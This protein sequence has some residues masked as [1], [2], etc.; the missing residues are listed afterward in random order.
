[1]AGHSKYDNGELP[2]GERREPYLRLAL[3]SLAGP[4]CWILHFA[5]VYL[6]EG[7]LCRQGSPPAQLITGVVIATTLVLAAGCA[8]LMVKSRYWLRKAGGDEVS[9]L[10]LLVLINRM[11]AG[12]SLLAIAWGGSGSLF[13]GPCAAGY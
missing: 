2:L 4:L 1:M 7:F 3:A 11:L 10:A 9:V 5:L 12:L 6:L 13:L 8:W